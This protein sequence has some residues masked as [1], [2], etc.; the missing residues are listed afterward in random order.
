MSGALPPET[1]LQDLPAWLRPLATAA[2]TVDASAL[3]RFLPPGD[4]SGR[5]SAV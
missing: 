1:A 5:A 2:R 3:S 4:G